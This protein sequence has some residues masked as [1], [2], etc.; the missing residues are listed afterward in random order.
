MR[1]GVG[2]FTNLLVRLGEGIG[3]HVDGLGA[4]LGVV[5]RY[6]KG[7]VESLSS[8]KEESRVDMMAGWLKEKAA[9]PH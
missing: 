7:E 9:P 2:W 6:V 3:S 4:E 5:V 1:L 8:H